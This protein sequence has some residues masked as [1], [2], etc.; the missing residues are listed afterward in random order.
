M[1]KLISRNITIPTKRSQDFSNAADSQ[2][3]I[4]VKIS[5]VVRDN[6]LLGNFNFV[7]IS[8]ALNGVP[9]GY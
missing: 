8:P 7:G 9:R 6:G 1:T 5:R 3:A 2:T 4:E